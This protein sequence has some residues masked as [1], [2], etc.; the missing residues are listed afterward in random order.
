MKTIS[1]NTPTVRMKSRYDDAD[2]EMEPGVSLPCGIDQRD[3]E[4][5]QTVARWFE[6][7]KIEF[8]DI[9]DVFSNYDQLKR[10]I[11]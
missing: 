4:D 7:T 6:S 10:Q 3:I 9:D 8:A 11:R 2:I 1:H 5:L